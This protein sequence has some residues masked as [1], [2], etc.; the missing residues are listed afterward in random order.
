VTQEIG[1]NKRSQI[2]ELRSSMAFMRVLAGL[3]SSF[4]FLGGARYASLA[5]DFVIIRSLDGL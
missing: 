1:L 4:G 2:D 5:L 3:A